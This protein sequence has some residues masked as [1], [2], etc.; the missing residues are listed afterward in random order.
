LTSHAIFNRHAYVE[1]VDQ[2]ISYKS[3]SFSICDVASRST[4]PTSKALWSNTYN[5][6]FEA[7]S[8]KVGFGWWIL[9]YN[10]YPLV[11]GF[12][13]NV[14]NN[15]LIILPLHN[16]GVSQDVSVHFSTVL[17]SKTS[18]ISWRPSKFGLFCHFKCLV[19]NHL[20]AYVTIQMPTLHFHFDRTFIHFLYFRTIL[21]GQ[22]GVGDW[23]ACS[24]SS[25]KLN[26]K[27]I[28]EVS[29]Y[30]VIKKT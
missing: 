17:M 11:L 14:T 19:N 7:N 13:M 15:L 3:S 22:G 21:S 29:L 27:I 26:P 23:E 24:V 5:N 8:T 9:F 28:K 25:S 2:I 12:G 1:Q 20:V 10:N 6:C 18:F 16:H 30:F 4:L